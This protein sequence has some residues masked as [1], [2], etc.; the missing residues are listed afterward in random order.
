MGNRFMQP[1]R[2]TIQWLYLFFIIF[3][4]IR[5]YQFVAHFRNGGSSPPVGPIAMSMRPS[6]SAVGVRPTP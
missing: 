2:I 4:G 1:L 6:S 3:L 5:F